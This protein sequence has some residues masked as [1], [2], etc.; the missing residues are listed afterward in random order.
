M[1]SLIKTLFSRS[2]T[3]KVEEDEAVKRANEALKLRMKHFLAQ[4]HDQ[5]AA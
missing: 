3:I 1:A 5:A 4:T 2:T